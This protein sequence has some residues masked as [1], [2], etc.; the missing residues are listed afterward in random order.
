LITG[1]STTVH[2][3]TGMDTIAACFL[4]PLGIVIYT[5]VGGLRASALL[6]LSS[7]EVIDAP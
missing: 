2:A 7:F 3:L 6:E 1:G 5:L 4:I